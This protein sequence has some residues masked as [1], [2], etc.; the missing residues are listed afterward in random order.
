MFVG[1]DGPL[2]C[3]M[4]RLLKQNPCQ[5][6]WFSLLSGGGDLNIKL[7]KTYFRVLKKNIL[8]PL[9]NEILKYVTQKLFD[10]IIQYKDNHKA[11]QAFDTLML[12][13]N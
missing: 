13:W 5:Y 11:W 12:L 9:G 3:L 10:Y 7:L 6:A 8:E 2:Y 1:P 4:R